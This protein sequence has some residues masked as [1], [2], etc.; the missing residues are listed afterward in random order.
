MSYGGGVAMAVKVEVTLTGLSQ[1]CGSGIDAMLS[2]KTLTC[3]VNGVAHHGTEIAVS[4][5]RSA[6]PYAPAP[7]SPS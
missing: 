3:Q 2:R 5:A 4:L 1:S 7:G 6:T